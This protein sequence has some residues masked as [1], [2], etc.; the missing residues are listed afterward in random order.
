MYMDAKKLINQ[1]NCIMKHEKI[2]EMEG[3]EIKRELQ[4]SQRSH[5]EER[6][7]VQLEHSGTMRD[8]EQKP[9]AAFTTEEETEIHQQRN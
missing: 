2:M 1:K 8:G 4:E 7:E 3:E 6:E 9:N 5:L